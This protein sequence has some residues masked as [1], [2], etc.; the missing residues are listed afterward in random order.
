MPGHGAD[1]IAT[2]R[3]TAIGLLRLAGHTNIATALRH[4]AP[5]LQP[6]HRTTLDMLKH[7][8]DAAQW[9]T[10]GRVGR[11]RRSWPSASRNNR[12]SLFASRSGT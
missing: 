5:R 4:H 1:A 10:L 12:W 6:A 8:F 2:L 7:D 9:A 3:N 11:V